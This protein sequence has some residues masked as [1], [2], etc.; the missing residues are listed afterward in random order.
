MNLKIQISVTI[1][2]KSNCLIFHKSLKNLRYPK[3]FALFAP[4]SN[5]SMKALLIREIKSFFGSPI[6]YLV[7]ALFLTLNGLFYGFLTGN[8]TF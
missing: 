4:Q 7:I 3:N 1:F 6:G 8:T 5:F 2:H